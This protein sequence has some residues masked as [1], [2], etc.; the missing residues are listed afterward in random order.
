MSV[1]KD[2]KISKKRKYAAYDS[3]ELAL[4]KLENIAEKA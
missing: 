3:I 1:P 4:N 2:P